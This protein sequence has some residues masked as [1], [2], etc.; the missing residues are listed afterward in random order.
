M[1]WGGGKQ[2][3]RGW[4]G[5]GGE[6]KDAMLPLLVVHVHAMAAQA[7][8]TCTRLTRSLRA[9]SACCCCFLSVFIFYFL[10]PFYP[11]HLLLT[12]LSLYIR[13]CVWLMFGILWVHSP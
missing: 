1:G 11:A 4:R 8:P 13:V 2:V 12:L 7:W 5:G 3:G 10:L 6:A 9:P